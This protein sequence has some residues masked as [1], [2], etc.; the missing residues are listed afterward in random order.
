[1]RLPWEWHDQS[2]ETNWRHCVTGPELP[3]FHKRKGILKIDQSVKL[4][5]HR[6]SMGV[7]GSYSLA[8]DSAQIIKS[9]NSS[10]RSIHYVYSYCI[11]ASTNEEKLDVFPIHLRFGRV[12]RPSSGWVIRYMYIAPEII[13]FKTATEKRARN[14]N[15]MPICLAC[16]KC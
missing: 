11:Y 9:D 1:M 14:Y 13:N 2:Q 15:I 8:P 4:P 10:L 6:H 5:W 3:F 7:A 12:Q 16:A